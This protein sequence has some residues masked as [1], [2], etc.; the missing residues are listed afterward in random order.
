[1]H[2]ENYT[3]YLIFYSGLLLVAVTLTGL[4]SSYGGFV[5]TLIYLRLAEQQRSTYFLD[6][7]LVNAFP[8]LTPQP[9]ITCDGGGVSMIEGFH[10]SVSDPQKYE[11]TAF[12]VYEV[13]LQL[14]GNCPEATIKYWKEAVLLAPSW[15]YYRIELAHLYL[16]LGKK[17]EALQVLRACIN[18]PSA[19]LHC[20]QMK[21]ELLSNWSGYQTGF[22]EETIKSQ[23]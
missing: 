10:F 9:T 20:E 11:K 14:V 13:G 1:M 8:I 19:R 4:V 22:L 6:R 15:S 21:D 12:L 7:F 23:L 3:S 2:K 18:Q 17:E 16:S 5:K